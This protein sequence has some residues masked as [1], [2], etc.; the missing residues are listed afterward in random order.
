MLLNKL[1][2]VAIDSTKICGSVERL[3]LTDFVM[4]TQVYVTSVGNGSGSLQFFLPF[5]SSKP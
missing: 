4:L 3:I 5:I 1:I 2:S